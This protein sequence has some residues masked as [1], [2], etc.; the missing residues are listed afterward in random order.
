MENQREL[1][2]KLFLETF[3]KPDRVGCPDNHALLGLAEAWPA[4]N[5]PL[6]RHVSSC[7]ECYR[8]YRHYR[9]EHAGCEA[10]QQ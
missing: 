4:P 5:D 8:E 2:Q 6:L 1:L 7:S 3:F 9:L 10:G